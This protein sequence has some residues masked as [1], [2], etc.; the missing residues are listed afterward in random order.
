MLHGKMRIAW[1][2]GLA[3]AIT[4]LPAMPAIAATS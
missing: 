3:A 1:V 2:M 4:V